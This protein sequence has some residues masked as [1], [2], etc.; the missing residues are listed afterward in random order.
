MKA[1]TR[2][3]FIQ[4]AG[5]SVRAHGA[6]LLACAALV[7]V[8]MT[9]RA[10]EITIDMVRSDGAGTEEIFNDPDFLNDFTAL[11]TFNHA[12]N[13]H[14]LAYKRQAGALVIDRI[15]SDGQGF[16]SGA[17]VGFE[18][19][20]SFKNY[21]SVM[22]FEQGG[23]AHFFF[24]RKE[25]GDFDIFRLKTDG[26][27]D[28]A[29]LESVFPGTMDPG[30]TIF[31]PFEL[32]GQP[33]YAAFKDST[34]EFQI[35]R[36]H[37]SRPDGTPVELWYNQWTTPWTL[38]APFVHNGQPHFITYQKE[39]GEATIQRIN[40]GGQ[41]TTELKRFP[42]FGA[43]FTAWVPFELDGRPHFL[44]YNANSGDASIWRIGLDGAS[45]ELRGSNDP[46]W[47]SGRTSIASFVLGGQPHLISYSGGTP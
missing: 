45:I 38:F 44:T 7:A 18:G 39:T 23:R 3:R 20:D 31:V 40:P 47:P 29:G 4:R 12:G 17:G 8:P 27:G 41:G 15:A 25:N 13:P 24:Y 35:V 22:A 36:I 26:D 10:G 2:F 46:Q 1:L 6:L 37:P 42:Q 21:T 30:W 34:R 5:R 11:V 14:M 32:N 28:A 16:V 43:G 19:D 33:H 9:A